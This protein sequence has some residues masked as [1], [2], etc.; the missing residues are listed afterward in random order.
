VRE[1]FTFAQ[2]A[3]DGRTSQDCVLADPDG[4][5]RGALRLPYAI[6]ELLRALL[7]D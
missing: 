4:G 1:L 5:R 7:R 6:E 3:A 2:L